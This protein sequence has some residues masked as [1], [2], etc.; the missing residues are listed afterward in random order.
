MEGQR[1][2]VFRLVASFRR[3]SSR[4]PRAIRCFSARYGAWPVG[5]PAA[6]ASS[7]REA[8]ITPRPR[9][10]STRPLTF[11]ALRRLHRAPTPR[12]IR[13]QETQER[14]IGT[15]LGSVG[16]DGVVDVRNSYAVPHNEQG[17]QVYVDV[18][19]H[20]A[21]VELHQK[22]NPKEQ[23]VGWY[24]TGD[25]VVPTDA[26][27][28]EFYAHECVNPVHVTLDTTFADRSKLMRA[29][30][31]QS[32][33]LGGAVDGDKASA[34]AAV[35][36]KEEAKEGEEAK[37]APAPPT[38]IHFQEIAL[39]NKFEEAERVGISL[40]SNPAT[41]KISSEMEGLEHTVAKLG[42]MLEKA[43]AYVGNVCDGKIPADAEIGRYLADTLAA[44]PRLT[45]EQFEKLF[46]DSIQDVLLVM[47]LS[48][49]TKMQLMLAEKLQ[50]PS[51]LI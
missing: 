9:F 37:A 32:L 13:R 50:T 23:I 43:A 41:E 18:E 46:G 42:G 1:G 20:R 45:R 15:L 38:A 21:M 47:Y 40:L 2:C 19:F 22:V 5:S 35:S 16:P 25:S 26:L 49:I 51:L 3:R 4:V 28:H 30:V 39:L 6:T 14:V 7:V 12:F 33:A 24:S 8:G 31:G 36:S 29:W 34:A 27:I 48:N 44:V 17:G 11:C 10:P